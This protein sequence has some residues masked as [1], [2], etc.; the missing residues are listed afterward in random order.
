M[1]RDRFWCWVVRVIAI[2]TDLHVL[3]FL[4]GVI[5]EKKKK[6]FVLYGFASFDRQLNRLGFPRFWVLFFFPSVFTKMCV[7]SKSLD[8]GEN[9]V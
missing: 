2:H 9:G 5:R 7:M 8:G 1:F 6:R 4:F 3:S